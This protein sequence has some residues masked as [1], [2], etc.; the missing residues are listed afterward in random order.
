MQWRLRLR[1]SRSPLCHRHSRRT[2]AFGRYGA[3][4]LC[5]PSGLQLAAAG[6]PKCR[7]KSA[8]WLCQILPPIKKRGAFA[9]RIVLIRAMRIER[10]KTTTLRAAQ[11]TGEGGIAGFRC[12]RST[13]ACHP[14]WCRSRITSRCMAAMGYTGLHG[15]HRPAVRP[16]AAARVSRKDTKLYSASCS[17]CTM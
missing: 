12:Q 1:A 11:V 10:S 15:E 5:R 13:E 17:S 9:A 16:V 3:A 2:S 6:K 14:R 8:Q 7:F 4:L